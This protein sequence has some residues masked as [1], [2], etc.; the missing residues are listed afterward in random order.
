L[1][2]KQKHGKYSG[3]EG[4][5]EHNNV[6]I[7]SKQQSSGAPNLRTFW[8]NGILQDL[9]KEAF[10]PYHWCL[11][12]KYAFPNENLCNEFICKSWIDAHVAVFGQQCV[13]SNYSL[14]ESLCSFH[15]PEPVYTMTSDTEKIVSAMLNT[16]VINCLCT[17]PPGREL[18]NTHTAYSGLC[19]WPP[20]RR[21]VQ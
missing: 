13:L 9:L 20:G 6:S 18:Y 21:A 10:E 16:H 19:T 11:L 7:Q 2:H 4:D 14:P 8:D 5:E 1:G 15:N 12:S 17:W 3:G